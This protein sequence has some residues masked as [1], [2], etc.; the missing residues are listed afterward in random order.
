MHRGNNAA[1]FDLGKCKDKKIIAQG[2][3]ILIKKGVNINN[4]NNFGCTPLMH[5]SGIKECVELLIK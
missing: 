3:G 5:Y 4:K 1:K 2:L